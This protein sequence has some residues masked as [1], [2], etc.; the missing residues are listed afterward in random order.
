MQGVPHYFVNNLSIHDDYDVRQFE[1][2]ALLV[3][4]DLFQ[5]NDVVIMTGGSGLYI[6][7]ICNGFDAIPEVDPE[8]RRSLNQLYQDEGITALQEKLAELDPDYYKQV[9]SHNPQRLIRGCEVTIGTG[10]PFSSYRKR[11]KINRPFQVIKVGLKR[12]RQELYD[13]I[14]LRMDQM[15]AAGLFDEAERLFPFR[16]L[17]ALQTVGYSEIF[18]YLEGR[19]DKD[20]AVRLLK[21]NSRRYAKR[22]MTWFRKDEEMQW[23]APD[24]YEK[25]VMFVQDQMGR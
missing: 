4:D 25:V 21:R 7:A 9:D 22:Q 8:I 24:E 3:L 15:I 6:D 19:Y 16:Q 10:K 23:F 1:K 11:N 2:D 14:N 12:E 20:E 5:T 17:N 13:R 18:G